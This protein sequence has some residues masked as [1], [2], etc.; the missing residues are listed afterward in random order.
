MLSR[1]YLQNLFAYL[2]VKSKSAAG[3]YT[4][5]SLK[6]PQIISGSN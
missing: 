3:I 6:F 1:G 5:I 2:V 4:K